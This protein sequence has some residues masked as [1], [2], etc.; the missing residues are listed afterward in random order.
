MATQGVRALL[1]GSVP[2]EDE[3]TVFRTV[4]GILGDRLSAIPDGETGV[5]TNWI[6]WQKALMD[7]TPMLAKRTHADGY[8]AVQVDVYELRD[9][10]D[11]RLGFG[12]LGYAEAAKSSY[13]KFE[14]LRREGAIPPGQRFQVSLPTPLAPVCAFIAPDHFLKV[15]PLYVAAM[16]R[17]VEEILAA[18][19]HDAL[20]IQ[21]DTALEFAL[22]EGVFPGPVSDLDELVD[23]LTVLSDWIP[24]SV[25]VGFHLCYGDANH[26]HFIEPRD[27]G[28][29]V[30]VA[31]RLSDRSAR[32]IDWLHFPVPI[33]RRDAAYF[34]PLAHLKMTSACEIYL[35]LIHMADGLEGALARAR[36]ARPY[37]AGFGIATECG[38]GRRPAEAVVPLL[39]LTAAIAHTLDRER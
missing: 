6:N 30:D 11:G 32:A 8:G 4:A 2:L 25:P 1:V 17:E 37:I 34:A 10:F 12:P 36:A 15:E 24:A 18:I 27:A 5:R 9:G 28:L 33:G 13:R 21:W 14:G 39:K 16:R 7:R 22:M 31:N 20:A 29:M 38:L 3:T 19:P 26:K 35:G 23:R